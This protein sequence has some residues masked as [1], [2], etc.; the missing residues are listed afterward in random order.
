MEWIIK[1]D[2][3]N[4]H[5]PFHITIQKRRRARRFD[6]PLRLAQPR[7]PS[8]ILSRIR[9]RTLIVERLKHN[10]NHFTRCRRII[11][12]CIPP[13]LQRHLDAKYNPRDNPTRV[14]KLVER[15]SIPMIRHAR[16]LP[17]APIVSTLIE[18]SRLEVY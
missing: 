18:R 17:I 13:F 11:A 10:R 16:A 12:R 9:V 14:G 1:T 6:T 5:S 3:K 15:R 7:N 4:N 8:P 2:F